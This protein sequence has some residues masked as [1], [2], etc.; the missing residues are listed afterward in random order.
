[1]VTVSGLAP[2]VLATARMV[3]VVEVEPAGMVTETGMSPWGRR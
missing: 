1:M 3:M 2:V